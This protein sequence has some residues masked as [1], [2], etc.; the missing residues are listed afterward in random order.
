MAIRSIYVLLRLTRWEG[1]Q[2]GFGVHPT[3]RTGK[4][5]DLSGT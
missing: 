4:T 5:A 1:G 2:L 3:A